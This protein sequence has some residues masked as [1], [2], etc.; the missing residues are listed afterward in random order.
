MLCIEHARHTSALGSWS[1]SH[2]S[3]AALRETIECI[4]E[5]EG[6]VTHTRER[7]FPNGRADLIVNLGPPQRLTGGEVLD[8][9]CVS[10]LQHRPLV[11]ESANQVHVFGV[12]LT[13]DGAGRLL[14]APAHLMSGRV[15][16]FADLAGS[17]ARSMFDAIAAAAS[18]GDR[19]V[20]VCRWMEERTASAAPVEPYV[21]W[22]ASRIETSGGRG[23]I[24][25]LRRTAR[26]SRK[27]LAADFRNQVG[28][29]PKL[30][31]RIVRFRR[32]AALLQQGG[33]SGAGA[34]LAAG[35][36]DQSHMALDFRELAGVAPGEFAAACYPDGN[37][38]LVL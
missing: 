2:C 19:A 21:A 30:L 10:G 33:V 6:T 26:V 16:P 11:I 14:G 38:A 13:P 18:F 5:V 15:L 4:W 37:S 17:R 22:L 32:A 31:A 35:Y 7:I 20:L 23:R 25:D 12:R 8:R 3:P 34:A 28:V 9:V 29:P 36:Y 27:K 24:E 1:F